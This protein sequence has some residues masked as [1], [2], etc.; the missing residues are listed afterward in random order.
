MALIVP[1]TETTA[2]AEAAETNNNG[3]NIT[4]SFN[5]LKT[6]LAWL[7]DH[8]ALARYNSTAQSCNKPILN[9]I[10]HPKMLIELLLVR[11]ISRET[12]LVGEVLMMVMLYT[13]R[14]KIL[15]LCILC[16]IAIN[17]TISHYAKRYMGGLVLR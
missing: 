12:S 13:A 10:I 9:V 17:I 7:Q 14:I 16:Q 5:V 4:T 2:T 1:I 8:P 3:L 15:P 6:P 11:W